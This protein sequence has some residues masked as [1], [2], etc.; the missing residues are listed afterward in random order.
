M[1]LVNAN[2][3]SF[4]LQSKSVTQD[5]PGIASN[6]SEDQFNWRPAPDRWSVSQSIEHLNITTE[7]YI[8][9]LTAA[10]SGARAAHRL[11]DG[12][13]VL[14]VIE[15]W[16]VG[17]MEPPP[18]RRFRTRPEFVA[19]ARLAPDATVQRFLVLQRQFTE[20]MQSAD[21][22]D[23]RRIKVRSQFGPVSWSLNGT[24]AILLAH[25]RRH[26]WQA[27]QVRKEPAFPA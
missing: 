26:V 6:L 2:V 11:A 10:I 24:F 12:P 27:R 15:R 1:A 3:E 19:P 16:F 25:Q 4:L 13:F 7:R 5:L 8:P 20:C 14:G 21:G 9:A 23:L 17:M 18:R 22:L